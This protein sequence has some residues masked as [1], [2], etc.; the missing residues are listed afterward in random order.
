MKL[1]KMR[2]L[3]ARLGIPVRTFQDWIKLDP[4]LG[5][6]IKDRHNG[7]WWIK[8]EKLAGRHGIGLI[9][10]YMLGEH[11]WIKAVDAAKI[12]GVSR[13][14]MRNW[15]NTRPGFAKRIGRVF[16]ID[17]H[18][19][20]ADPESVEKFFEGDSSQNSQES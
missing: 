8:V 7:S 2:V 20:G 5:V 12:M 11:R 17:L 4:S 1:I 6:F 3:A 14:T 18:D 15:C 9:D 13:H 10:S 19:L 16:Y